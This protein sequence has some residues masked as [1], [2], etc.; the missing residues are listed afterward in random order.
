MTPSREESGRAVIEDLGAE[1][2]DAVVIDLSRLPS[3]GRHTA[4]AIRDQKKTRALPLVFVD[5]RP[6]KVAGVREALPDAV[7][8]AWEEISEAVR[9]AI[10]SP[11]ATPVAPAARGA[12]YSG[13]PLAKKLG[14]HANSA[15]GLVD[16]PAGI[17]ALL[18]P[19]PEGVEIKRQP[20]AACDLA[21]VFV[22]ERRAL[23]KHLDRLEKI[24]REGAVWI[25]WPKK[26]AK[27]PTDV[28]EDVVRECALARG[29]VDI[30][31]CAVDATWSG[32]RLARRR[33]PGKS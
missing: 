19:L 23:E 30:K 21:L 29:L 18:D 17:E 25:S 6:D 10:A 9:R 14:I 12:G 20:R 16:A 8:A 2:P 3:H 24:S 1:L 22:T 28:T 4:E 15:L 32:L 31:V 5:G 13:T 26:A 27:V 33:S 7:Y 11:P